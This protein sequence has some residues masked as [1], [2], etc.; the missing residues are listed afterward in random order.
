MIIQS[1]NGTELV[2]FTANP[3]SS[4]SCSVPQPS[5]PCAPQCHQSLGLLLLMHTCHRSPKPL[6]SLPNPQVFC[7]AAPPASLPHLHPGTPAAFRL[8][9]CMAWVYNCNQDCHD[10]NAVMLMLGFTTASHS[11]GNPSS[12]CHHDPSRSHC[13]NKTRL[14]AMTQCPQKMPMPEV[15]DIFLRYSSDWNEEDSAL[16]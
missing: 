8:M 4:G 9:I 7:C 2:I 13:S 11:N 12:N 16:S 6:A 10:R 15:T 3:Q 14:N 5:C 1:F